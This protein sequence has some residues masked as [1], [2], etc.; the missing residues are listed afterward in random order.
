MPATSATGETDERT[1]VHHHSHLTASTATAH[2]HPGRTK[3]YAATSWDVSTA[4]GSWTSRC[5][6]YNDLPRILIRQRLLV[7]LIDQPFEYGL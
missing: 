3:G 7:A 1:H 6:W 2:S 5:T 4:A